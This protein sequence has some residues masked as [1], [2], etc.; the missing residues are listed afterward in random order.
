MIAYWA[1]FSANLRSLLRYRVAALAGFLTQVFWALL[2]LSIFTAFYSA[3]GAHERAPLNAH[4]LTAYVW[5][6]QALF[7]LLPTRPDPEALE[8][9]RE[10]GLA[11]ELTR[12]V[13]LY[14]FWF[15]RS[16]ALRFAPALLRLPLVVSFAC[17]VPIR[18]WSLA[19]PPNAFALVGFVVALAISV[20]LSGALTAL[21]SVLCLWIEGGN[22]LAQ[23]VAIFAWITSGL[24]LPLPM[25]PGPLRAI[26]EW[27]PF[28]GI[29]DSPL[30][31]YSGQVSNAAAA[32]QL[33]RSLCWAFALVAIG[34]LLLRHI[35]ERVEVQGG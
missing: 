35:L 18:A 3:L 13:D 9:V 1:Y 28:S 34:R 23:V 19:P 21:L 31:I 25:L 10:G 29:L 27:L 8:L 30:R 2:R 4:E 14:A 11:Y 32:L 17:L 15:S 33:A 5:L 20:F 22:G 6:G 7:V 24:L 12:P 16:V 26:A